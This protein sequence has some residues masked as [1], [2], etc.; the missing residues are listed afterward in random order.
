VH[1][2][3]NARPE[4]QSVAQGTSALR[5]DSS[6]PSV[7]TSTLRA[8]AQP[9]PSSNPA[10][11][12]LRVTLI[13]PA[14]PKYRIPVFRELAARPGIDLTLV[15]GT[16]RAITNV[17]P[18]GFKG[19]PTDF[20]PIP[21]TRG[22]LKWCG[23]QL[24]LADRAVTDVLVLPWNVHTLSIVPALLKARRRGIGT[25]VWGHGVSKRESRTRR[26]LRETAARFADAALLYT[27]S[28][29]EDLVSRGWDPARVFAAPNSLDQG[30]IRTAREHWAARSPADLQAFRAEHGLDAGPVLLFVSRLEPANRV[31]LV[32]RAAAAL[33][34]AH[35][36]L[37]VVIVGHGTDA[38]RLKTLVSELGLSARVIFTGAIYEEPKLAPWF[39]SATLFAYPANMGLSM[40][41]AMGY[42][43]PV[44]TGDR[45]QT[46]GP[47]VEALRDG[48]S[49]LFFR[50]DDLDSLTAAIRRI[51][52]DPSLRARMS[53]Q[54]LRTAH[55][56]YTLP[57]MVDQME[58]A[59]RYAASRARR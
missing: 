46:H 50:H 5:A 12:P 8:D 9:Q 2:V 34:P 10:T 16:E 17:L 18:D 37:K 55:E 24:R 33:A 19:H 36:G 32:L 52:D 1:Q 14:L 3:D 41:H 15:Y 42:G 27:R 13:Q 22:G 54:A 4:P 48:E 58:A 44:V 7:D 59:I 23:D 20:R 29:A 43:V 21:G 11:T 49:G 53:A 30:A 45:L 6:C 56:L 39:L 47:E 38:D 51:I 25:V 40:F 28:V 35:P 31:D 57:R 26:L